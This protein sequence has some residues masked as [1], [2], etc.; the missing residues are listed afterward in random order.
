MKSS[1]DEETFKK[2]KTIIN[3]RSAI[4][5]GFVSAISLALD[6]RSRRQFL[7]VLTMSRMIDTS[8]NFA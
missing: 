5:A 1:N 8:L 2:W 6:A 4:V 7:A 3:G